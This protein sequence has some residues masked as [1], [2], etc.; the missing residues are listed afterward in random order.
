V[1]TLLIVG[2][3][4][5]QRTVELAQRDLRI[6][7]APENDLVLPDPTKGVSRMHAELRFEGGR[8]VIIDLN[9]QNGT[10]VDGNRIQRAEIAPNSQIEIGPYRL[11]MQGAATGPAAT[12]TQ[13]GRAVPEVKTATLVTAG[14]SAP[15]ASSTPAAPAPTPAKRA[16]RPAARGK[17]A[18]KPGLIAALAR[19]PKPMLF[20]GFFAI[21]V[22]IVVLGQLFAPADS[23]PTG[24]NAQPTEQKPAGESNNQIIARHLS[25][26][27]ALVEKG[28][29]EAAIRD[30]FDRILL[31]DSS[32]AE[33]TDLRAKTLEKLQQQKQ[34]TVVATDA[35]SSV[36]PP[37]AGAATTIPAPGGTAPAAPGSTASPASTDTRAPVSTPGLRTPAP[38]A[39]VQ[40]TTIQPA[41][42]SPSGANTPG[43]AGT[44]A[45][46]PRGRANA[47]GGTSAARGAKTVEGPVPRRPGES[48]QAWRGR[49][50]A[51]QAKY[52][53]AKAALD[54]GE[55]AAAAAGFDA[56]LK[57]EPGFLDAPQLLI[58]SR[59][60][61]RGSARD[62][63]EAGNKLDASGDWVAA[64]QKYDLAR[65]IDPSLAGLDEAAKRVHEKMRVAGADAFKRARQYDALGR[66]AEA[67]KDYEKAA[68]WLPADDSN[69]KVARD[70]AD[71]LKAG[72]K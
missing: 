24:T 7:R 60:G 47:G 61:Q 28:E 27:K 53:S 50:T 48:A 5:A 38:A 11:S 18:A 64:L 68:Q 69:R 39:P 32:H 26:G 31:I 15:G 20:G 41:P 52:T 6:G 10:W 57:E 49:S 36:P 58:R 51:L 72:V 71:Q 8:Y 40:P 43:P 62:A 42:G 23:S 65:Q 21:A 33:A 35:A 70:R 2:E 34:A 44:A 1:P 4:G 55:F 17:E 12:D 59:E 22:V 54:R 63:F 3:D 25:E 56:I 46:G 19:M 37:D 14:V 66:S 9:S 13:V 67:L 16:A 29:Y 30:H 45:V